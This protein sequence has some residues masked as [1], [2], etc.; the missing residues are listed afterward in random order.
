MKYVYSVKVIGWLERMWVDGWMDGRTGEMS[1]S[2]KRENDQSKEGLKNSLIWLSIYQSS[3]GFSIRGFLG[4]DVSINHVELMYFSS[5]HLYLITLED[6]LNKHVQGF[7]LGEAE[8]FIIQAPRR[9]IIQCFQS[10]VYRTNNEGLDTAKITLAHLFLSLFPQLFGASGRRL[11]FFAG[12]FFQRSKDFVLC[13][14]VGIDVDVFVGGFG[15][16]S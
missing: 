8:G 9:R 7:F 14:S 2:T 12:G 1:L 5:L 4:V 16:I 6:L 15:G 13:H 11:P 3:V 10:T